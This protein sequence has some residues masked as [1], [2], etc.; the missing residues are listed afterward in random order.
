MRISQK[1]SAAPCWER[2]SFSPLLW[3]KKA[4]PIGFK[5]SMK[6]SSSTDMDS[7]KLLSFVEIVEE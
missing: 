3:P 1:Y 4:M 7:L 6:P 5:K 2:S